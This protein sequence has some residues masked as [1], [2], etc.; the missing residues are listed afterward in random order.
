MINI[1]LLPH[2][3]K[4]KVK[5][6]KHSANI[7]SICLIIVITLSV[8]AILLNTYKKDLLQS[9]L[10]SYKQDI[11]KNNKSLENFADL[12]KKAL[13]LNDRVK[14]AASIENIRPSWSLIVQD[15]INSVPSNVRFVSLTADLSKSPNFVL[16]GAAFSERDAIK[17]KDKLESSKY[18]K[19]VAFKSAAASTSKENTSELN[20]SLEF[21]L[22]STS[23][24]TKGAK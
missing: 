16:Q 6:S 8:G 14:L 9:Q 19:D 10:E 7:F 15:L 11:A 5:K 2:D 22:E 13:F 4:Q 1:N 12:Q 18:F 23:A 21:N 3:I 24:A 17:F 20:F